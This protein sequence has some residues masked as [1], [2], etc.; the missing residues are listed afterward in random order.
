MLRVVRPAARLLN[1]RLALTSNV[2]LPRICA[3]FFAAARS[4]S[5]EEIYQKKT[6]RE[7]ILLRPETYI[8]PVQRATADC[9]V[10]DV[11]SKKIVRKEISYTPALYKIFDEILVNAAD[12]RHRGHNMSSIR[13]VID[14]D[15][16]LISIYNDGAAIPVVMHDKEKMFVPGMLFY[17]LGIF[18]SLFCLLTLFHFISQN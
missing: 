1:L 6:Q 3:R 17:Q 15:A 10:H 18:C 14:A 13:V 7:H 11:E 16:N 8:G 4:K 12:N 5:V 9:W 2:A